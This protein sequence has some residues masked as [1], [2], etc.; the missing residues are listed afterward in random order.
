VPPSNINEDVNAQHTWKAALAVPCV[1]VPISNWSYGAMVVVA[2]KRPPVYPEGEAAT[3]PHASPVAWTF[4]WFPL[5]NPVP[6]TSMTQ[7]AVIGQLYVAVR[8][9]FRMNVPTSKL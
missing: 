1:I 9:P 5:V 7:C 4:N 6:V 8:G 2:E 3:A